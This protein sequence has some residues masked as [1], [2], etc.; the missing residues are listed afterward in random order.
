MKTVNTLLRH[1]SLV[2]IQRIQNCQIPTLAIAQAI[3]Q[4]ALWW[5][6][7]Y[8]VAFDSTQPDSPTVLEKTVRLCPW[9]NKEVSANANVDQRPS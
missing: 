8:K 5:K 6:L 3:D 2:L 9:P 1:D 4:S 7:E